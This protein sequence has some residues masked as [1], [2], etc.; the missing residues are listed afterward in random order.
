MK[1]MHKLEVF[2]P[3]KKNNISEKL[4]YLYKNTD[5]WIVNSRIL[6]NELKIIRE[7][8]SEFEQHVKQQLPFECTK[9][10]LGFRLYGDLVACIWCKNGFCSNCV[11]ET[12]DSERCYSCKKIMKRNYLNFCENAEIICDDCLPE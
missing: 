8:A 3:E 9:C 4:D 11:I 2:E 10:G 5:W 12:D 1:K 7:Y 6:Q